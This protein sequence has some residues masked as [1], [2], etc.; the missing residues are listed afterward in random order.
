MKPSCRSA[1]T[2][3]ACCPPART[4]V[5][6]GPMF[7]RGQGDQM[8]IRLRRRDA[9]AIEVARLG[10]RVRQPAAHQQLILA[11]GGHHEAIR[12]RILAAV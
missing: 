9:N 8:K 12:L 5:P 6:V 11:V 10:H 3:N 4:V 7:A 2:V 1:K